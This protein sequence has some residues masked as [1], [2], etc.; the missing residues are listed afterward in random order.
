MVY[1]E[2]IK[3]L[4]HER[5]W[6]NK[7][8]TIPE[9]SLAFYA[10]LDSEIFPGF[11]YN[12][13]EAGQFYGIDLFLS[14]TQE[15]TTH[16]GK[17]IRSAGSFSLSPRDERY[18]RL[19]VI[20]EETLKRKVIMLY[21]NDFA[22]KFIALFFPEGRVNMVFKD[23]THLEKIYARMK[24]E[25]MKEGDLDVPVVSGIRTEL[26]QYLKSRQE[27]ETRPLLISRILSYIENN[28]FEQSLCREEIAK[29]LSISLSYLDK[30]FRKEISMSVNGYIR[31]KRLQQVARLL[32]LPHLRTKE[33]AASSGFGSTIYMDRLFRKKYGMTPSQYRKRLMIKE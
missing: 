20:G 22:R 11:T 30:L 1:L 18:S 15:T 14:G 4:Y 24:E 29:K 7:L 12:R 17:T 19:R 10:F 33:I 25:F 31:E 28:L 13:E 5:Y 21:K 32:S 16:S 8:E 9:D 2:N 23:L 3:T 27:K 6:I 26:L